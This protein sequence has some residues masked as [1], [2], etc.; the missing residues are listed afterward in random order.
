MLSPPVTAQGL[1]LVPRGR[2]QNAQFRGGMQLQQLPQ[3]HTLKRAE[4]PGMLIVEK[5]L[6][7]PRPKALDHTQTIL[8]IT[9]YVNSTIADSP[10]Q[11][12]QPSF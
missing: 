6:R 8:R 2:C 10:G 12:P 4:A 1:Q 5:L 11:V 3:R 7:F 9:L